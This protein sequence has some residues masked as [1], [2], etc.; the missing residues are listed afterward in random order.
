MAEMRYRAALRQ[1]IL[2]EMDRD[3]SVVML[4]QDI[5]ALG[6]SFA[7]SKGLLDRFGSDRII[8]TPISESAIVG[9]GV[10]LAMAG[11]R[12]IVELMFADFLTLGMDHVVNSAAKAI[13]ASGGEQGLPLVVRTPYG[14]T[15]S[16]MHHDQSPE[17]WIAN[18]PGITIAMP[19]SAG[20]AKGMLKAAIRSNN[21]VVFLEHKSLYRS[22]GQVPDGDH[23]VP[24]GKASITR[25]GKDVTIIALGAM[26]RLAE[27]AAE[28]LAHEGVDVEVVDIRSIRPLDTETI[29]ESVGRT[30]RAI[31]AHEAP[32]LYGIGGEIAS[33]ISENLFSRLVA[34]VRRI[35]APD[36][37]VPY[38]RDHLEWYLPN[39]NEFVETVRETM[40]K[41]DP[42]KEKA[43]WK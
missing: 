3:S 30:R 11:L 43:T 5:G 23:V 6:G 18:V 2:E 33:Q 8:E 36:T 26:V 41:P 31:V 16:G 28:I 9:T 20:D 13:F 22:S 7:V 12:P 4:G 39:R 1:A 17:A 19:T 24:L 37:P 27:Q 40:K 21:P 29:F 42:Q 25:P 15:G 35:G 10:G 34:P 14:A 38:V 32:A